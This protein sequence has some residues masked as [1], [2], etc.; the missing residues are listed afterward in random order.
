MNGYILLI[1]A[2]LVF[3]LYD[4]FVKR[5]TN[6]E[7]TIQFIISA[8]FFVVITLLPFIKNLSFNYPLQIWIILVIY[9]ILATTGYYF[10]MK[11]IQETELSEFGPITSIQP[12]FVLLVGVLIFSEHL[13]VKQTFGA[14]LILGSFYFMESF[15]HHQFKLNQILKNPNIKHFLIAAAIFAIL[16]GFDKAL[17]FPS[18]LGLSIP[19]MNSFDILFFTR[20]A[21]LINMIILVLWKF[22]GW[23]DIK[24]GF[25]D[26]KDSLFA[27]VCLNAGL[28]LYF[29]GIKVIEIAIAGLI[30][31]VSSLF[32]VFFGHE[33]FHDHKVLEKAIFAAIMIAGIALLLL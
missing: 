29:E 21:M 9:G 19:P 2:A 28:F 24:A 13:D 7:K 8:Q 26:W 16:Y 33:M 12:L 10:F 17:L 15:I 22:N 4:V 27:A 14:I 6:R 5:G 23:Q 1:L 30:L 11:T 31:R 25:K 20:V 32:D 18:S 3:A